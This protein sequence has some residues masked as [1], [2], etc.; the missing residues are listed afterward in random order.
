[1]LPRLPISV[2]QVELGLGAGADADHDDPAAH[3]QRLQVAGQVRAADQLED[4][5]VG[6]LRPRSS[7]GAIACTPSA[8]ICSRACSLRTVAVTRAPAIAPS[9]T[10]GHADAAGRAVDEQPLADGQAAPG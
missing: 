9:W 7:S 1:M 3:R 6:A 5:V 8:A 10:R 2:A 4:H